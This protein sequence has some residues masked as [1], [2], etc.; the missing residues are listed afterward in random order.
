MKSF[1][2]AHIWPQRGRLY[3]LG[4]LWVR[5]RSLTE[6]MLQNVFEKSF[7]RQTELQDHP[8]LTGWLVSS[9]KNEILMHFRQTKKLESLEGLE[10]LRMEESVSEDTKD[11]VR[12]VMNLVKTLPLRQQEIFH[13]REVEGMSYE[14][15]TEYLDISLDQVKVNLHRARKSIRERMPNQK[16]TK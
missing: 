9:L 12:Q 1:F 2:E 11:S 14:E 3:R 6:D 10:E 4:Y 16:S 8:N 13:L 7:G 5:D 15:I